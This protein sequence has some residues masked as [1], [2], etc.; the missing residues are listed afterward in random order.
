MFLFYALEPNDTVPFFYLPQKNTFIFLFS[1]ICRFNDP[2]LI[3]TTQVKVWILV[4]YQNLTIAKKILCGEA[5]NI[6]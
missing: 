3:F 2:I 1:F 6:I 5:L 4:F